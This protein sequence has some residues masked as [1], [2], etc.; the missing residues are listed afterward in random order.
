MAQKNM[1]QFAMNLINRN[2]QVANNPMAQELI[3]VIQ[4]GSEQQGETIAELQR[5]LSRAS[6]R[7]RFDPDGREG[8]EDCGTGQP[9]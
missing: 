3:G 7:D 1:I 9:D 2:P 5:E 6:R 8:R 4:N